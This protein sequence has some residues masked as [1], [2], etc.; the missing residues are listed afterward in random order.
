MSEPF[1]K[2]KIAILRALSTAEEPIGSA[3]IAE[4]IQAAGYE[5]S[6]RTIRLYLE[7]MEKD[8]LVEE[9]KRGR[10]GGRCITAKGIE[11]IRDAM[12]VERVGLTASRVDYL[13]SQ[14][15]FNPATGK[16]LVLVNVT[17]T[18]EDCLERA[19]EVMR[20]VFQAN[21]GMGDRVALAHEGERIGTVIVP[22]NKM[23]IATVC[24]VTL[25]GILLGSRIPML[26][27]FGGVLEV[28]DR[29]PIRF[30]DMIH[31][32]GTSLDPLEI[33]IKAG[34]LGVRETA[35]TGRGRIGASFREIPTNTLEEAERLFRRLDKLGLGGILMVGRP[36]QPVL[37]FP[38][39]EG[40]TGIIVA[41]GLNPA[42]AL[43]EA[44]VPNEN[45]ALSSLLDYEKMQP[46]T[47]LYQQI[48]KRRYR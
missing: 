38:V 23:A 33:F 43:Q 16:G 24:S 1:S 29:F 10:N 45:H 46:F 5:L 30:T 48:D 27:R 42:A 31:Y 34:L 12:V 36:N 9:A 44:A 3:A 4:R 6:S 14:M 35:R 47:D 41:G 15:T 8:G 11:E 25:H 22:P 32:A 21:L 28:N 7:D 18:D 19:V 37:D 40:R 26:A 17:V 20:P 39:D 13:S 2:Q